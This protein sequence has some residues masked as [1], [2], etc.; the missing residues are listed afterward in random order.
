MWNPRI[1]REVAAH[2]LAT[3][4]ARTT[5]KARMA[6]VRAYL[7]VT[8]YQLGT[9]IRALA[10]ELNLD[11]TLKMPASTLRSLVS[12]DDPPRNWTK[13]E[14]YLTSFVLI[15][16]LVE[17]RKE[18]QPAE[19]E[20]PETLREFVHFAADARAEIE[21]DRSQSTSSEEAAINGVNG[22]DAAEFEN[23]G[24]TDELLGLVEELVGAK[25]VDPQFAVLGHLLRFLDMQSVVQGHFEFGDEPEW[26]N[27]LDRAQAGICENPYKGYI[28]Y[29]FDTVANRVVKSF[30]LIKPPGWRNYTFARFANYSYDP[31]VD[32]RPV[33]ADSGSSYVFHRETFGIIVPVGN[34]VCLIGQIHDGSAMKMMVMP[35]HRRL[36]THRGL[37]LSLGSNHEIMAARFVMVACDCENSLEARLDR[38]ASNAEVLADMHQYNLG[39]SDLDAIRNS[40]GFDTLSDLQV[41]PNDVRFNSA[42]TMKGV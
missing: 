14:K 1:T 23:S 25:S 6:E 30:T 31:D 36:R 26:L 13:K 2:R 24:L 42:L 20:F 21:A 8:G 32:P 39:V 11:D 12:V 16:M 15:G 17:R 28:T 18:R 41:T 38:F 7:C 35:K 10:D 19:E 34:F 4:D 3:K 22:F 29:S 37:L 27:R 9:D 5:L 40:V 33:Y